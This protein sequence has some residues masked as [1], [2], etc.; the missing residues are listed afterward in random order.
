MKSVKAK[1]FVIRTWLEPGGAL[2][3]R[4]MVTDLETRHARGFS[5]FTD[6]VRHLESEAGAA[7]LAEEDERPKS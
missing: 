6:L 2:A 5:R 7:R 3:W 1:S 4:G